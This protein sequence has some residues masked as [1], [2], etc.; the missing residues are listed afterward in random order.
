MTLALAIAFAVALAVF[1][2]SLAVVASFTAVWAAL[3]FVL[4][5]PWF[6]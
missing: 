5:R 4:W 2:S 6:R 3:S 1:G